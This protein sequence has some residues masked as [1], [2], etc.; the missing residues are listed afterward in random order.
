[1]QALSG[2]VRNRFKRC[3]LAVK[4]LRAV[5]EH[6][7]QGANAD[8][9]EKCDDQDGDRAAKQRL[10]VQQPPICRFGNRLR[11]AFDGI[12]MCRR[13]RQS[14]AR[15]KWPPFGISP[16]TLETEGCAASLSESLVDWNRWPLI[17]RESEESN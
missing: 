11:E 6:L 7:H 10:G 15:H 8:R 5:I 17:C 3:S 14:G 12:G 2:K 9:R 4:S 13:T 16:V 1:M